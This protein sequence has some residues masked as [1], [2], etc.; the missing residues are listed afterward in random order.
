[1]ANGEVKWSSIAR[2]SSGI[3][4]SNSLVRDGD[5]WSSERQR[6]VVK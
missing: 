2:S 1:M 6:F 4:S 3:E 5:S